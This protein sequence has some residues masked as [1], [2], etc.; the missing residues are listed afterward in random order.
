[1]DANQVFAT[2]GVSGLTGLILFI[3]Y[4]FLFTKHSIRSRCC[5]KE[6][7]LETSGDDTPKKTNPLVELRNVEVRDKREPDESERGTNGA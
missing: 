3:V 6:I 5:G 2:G 4:K 7:A 1:M